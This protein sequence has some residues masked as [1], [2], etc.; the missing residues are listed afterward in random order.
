MLTRRRKKREPSPLPPMPTSAEKDAREQRKALSDM[1]WQFKPPI[2]SVDIKTGKVTW[3]RPL[4][5]ET[6]QC[7]DVQ[8]G[9]A[10]DGN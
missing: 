2:L 1:E 9:G 5:K 10:V 6:R 3:Y 4:F 8:K 7:L